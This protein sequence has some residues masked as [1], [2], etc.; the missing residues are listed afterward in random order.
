MIESI[1]LKERYN[2]RLKILTNILYVVGVYCTPCFPNIIF[3]PQK[4][5]YIYIYIRSKSIYCTPSFFH[6]LKST[7]GCDEKVTDCGVLLLL[8]LIT[9]PLFY[10]RTEFCIW[11]SYRI[12]YHADVGI[13]VS[14]F[15]CMLHH[16][17]VA[18]YFF[19]SRIIAY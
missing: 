1:N 14:A 13:C 5:I 10:Q 6:K 7:F 3:V 8:L 17:P 2:V 4:K 19:S 18:L 9:S 12:L 15:P 11:Y 16:L